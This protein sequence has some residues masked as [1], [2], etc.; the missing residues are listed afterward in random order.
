MATQS[1]AVQSRKGWRR[2]ISLARQV[3][4]V[5]SAL[6][7]TPGE[8]PRAGSDSLG[9]LANQKNE[10]DMPSLPAATVSRLEHACSSTQKQLVRARINQLDLAQRSGDSALI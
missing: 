5:A 8:N 10:S 1:T 4:K 9:A 6:P 7:P 3:M 2:L